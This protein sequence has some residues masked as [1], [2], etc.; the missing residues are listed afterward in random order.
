MK[1]GDTLFIGQYLFT[2]SETTSLWLEVCEFL[3]S[4]HIHDIFQYWHVLIYYNL[5]VTE[6]SGKEVICYVKNTATLSGPIFT[7]HVSQVHIS[8]PTL[9]EYDKQVMCTTSFCTTLLRY[10]LS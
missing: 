9:S 10:T 7:L 2:G 4:P 6:T 3:D 1:K 8:M 5:Q